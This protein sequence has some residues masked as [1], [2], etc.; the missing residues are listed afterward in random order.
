MFIS[1]LTVHCLLMAAVVPAHAARIKEIASFEGIRSNPLTGYGLVVGLD[2][3]GDKTGTEFTIQSLVN[4]LN[5]FGIKVNP[6]NVKVKNVAAVMVTAELSPSHRAGDRI[7][8]T[9]SS[10]GDAKSLQGGTLLF[11]PLRGADGSIYVIAQGAVSIGGFIGGGEGGSVQKNHLLAGRAPGGGFVEKEIPLQFENSIALVLRQ[12]DFTTSNKIT[13]KINT[14]FGAGVAESL[15]GTKIGIKIPDQY[16]NS[17]FVEFLSR[18]EGLDVSVDAVSRVVVNERT[19]TIVMGENVRISTV[20]VSHGSL[21]VEIKIRPQV[22]Q[23]PPFSPG[24]TVVTTEEEAVVKEEKSRLL[25]VEQGATLGD[26]VKALNAIGVT[27]RDLISIL[28]AVK[29]AGALQAE[30]EII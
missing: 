12:S 13:E 6:A 4:M 22:S 8:V 23:P 1:L 19:G 16:K 11:T 28:Q 3:T 27:P 24:Q 10:I 7:D 17:G 25:V 26:L 9:I 30:L 5:R 20:A 14:A 2:G 29:A 21:T 18:I 15:D